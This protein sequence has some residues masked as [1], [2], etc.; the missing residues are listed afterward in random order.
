MG[1]ISA[2]ILLFRRAGT[3]A[4]VFLIH[5]GGP[6]WAK[7]D[8]G[9]WSIPKGLIEEGE[10]P[11][12]AALREFHEETGQD[13]GG[14]ASRA[15]R[16]DPIRQAGGKTVQAWTVE[17][18][19]DAEHILSNSFKV[20]SPAGSGRWRSYPEADRAAW[21]PLLEASEKIVGGQR[22]LLAQLAALLG[23]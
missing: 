23:C 21:L 11:L 18:D 2:G 3:C 7:K 15:R 9:A 20:E 10:D 16:L 17:G 1:Q 12:A 13:L 5:M 4:E 19:A 22:D 6:F 8:A 14:V